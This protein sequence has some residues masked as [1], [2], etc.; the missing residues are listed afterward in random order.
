MTKICGKAVSL[1]FFKAGLEE[2]SFI[3]NRCKREKKSPKGYT[4]LITHAR[5]CYGANFEDEAVKHLV[6]HGHKVGPNGTIGGKIDQQVIDSFYT[7]NEKERRMYKWINWIACRNQALSEV[8]N[9]LTRDL[10]KI[11]TVCTKTLRKAVIATASNTVPNISKALNCSGAITLLFDGWSC[12]G[13][14]THYVAIF[15]GFIN[16]ADEYEEV[17]LSLQP[18]FDETDLGADAHIELIESTLEMYSVDPEN[19]VCLVGDNC[20]TNHAIARRMEIPLIGCGNHRLNLAVKRFIEET[21]GLKDAIGKVNTLMT[22]ATTLKNAARLRDLTMARF[23]KYIVAK[24][25]N[26]IRWTSDFQ[27]VKRFLLLE[28]ELKDMPSLELSHDRSQN[29]L[30]SSIHDLA[31]NVM[32]S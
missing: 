27:M 19:V 31:Y 11:K 5:V 22:K 3:C 30:L 20:S 14:S 10:A 7:S 23:G 26:E 28:K 24:K 21:P 18:T 17:L 25:G 9:E 4:N 2:N 8:E 6:N 15:A 29:S 1:F 32:T 16:H 13:S 12:D